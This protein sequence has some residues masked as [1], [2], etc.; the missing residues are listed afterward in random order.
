MKHAF[1]YLA[2][3]VVMILAAGCSKDNPTTP[4]GDELKVTAFAANPTAITIG[5]SSV[6]SWTIEGTPTS[7]TIDNGV[8]TVTSVSSVAVSPSATT[9]Y[10]LTATKGSA[11]ATKSVTVTVSN[12]GDPGA[13]PIPLALTAAAGVPG[14]INLSWT[15][16]S[17]ASGYMVERK[18][19][20]GAFVP[21]TTVQVNSYTDGGLLAGTSYTYRVRSVSG[22]GARS[23]WSNF[24][25]ATTSGTAP[26][27]E[28]ITLLP[29]SA[30]TLLPGQTVQ[31]TATAYDASNNDLHLAANVF[32]WNSSNA[33]VVSIGQ[34]G[35]ATAGNV[36]GSSV[37][38][39]QI[40]EVIS[41]SVN[42]GVALQE[43]TVLVI[44]H[45]ESGNPRNFAIYTSA[46]T[47]AL[48]LGK[49]DQ[50]TDAPSDQ[51]PG[52]TFDQIKKYQKILFFS[53]TDASL[54]A[55][56]IG[57]FKQ[58]LDQ[59][60]KRLV[61]IG[62]SYQFSDDRGFQSYIGLTN[63]GYM[64]LD[65]TELGFVGGAGTAMAGFTFDRVAA[66]SYVGDLTLK[67]NSNALAALT[68]K[69]VSSGEDVVA[70]IQA[71]VAGSSKIFYSGLLLE[72]IPTNQQNAFM[73]RLANN[74]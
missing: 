51:P 46:M 63:D 38:S 44:Y 70:A 6:L 19:A 25:T 36:Q 57:L 64:S 29:T 8:G 10:T 28:R 56:T 22:S 15:I 7:V 32:T 72:N 5:D 4:S 50:I 24:A 20:G 71:D 48:G 17:G 12:P 45:P 60:N 69:D 39:A 21:V 9:T 34:T 33:Q 58:Y 49:F 74:F 53:Q 67:E 1:L 35:L 26:V 43:N 47:S 42:V 61:V 62:E 16:S 66:T 37:V 18:S 40:G 27:V 13:P 11:T 55:Q 73:A 52:F 68:T 41:N 2:A 31:F 23:G 14:A 3:L 59:G 54:N 65:N 30:P